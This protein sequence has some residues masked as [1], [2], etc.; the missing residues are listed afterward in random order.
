MK[1][2]EEDTARILA[3]ALHQLKNPIS[4]I[5]GSCEYLT[6]YSQENLEPEQREMVA[7]IETSAQTLLRLSGEL[8]RLFGLSGP[9]DDATI[10]AEETPAPSEGPPADA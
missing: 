2:H 8:S 7:A 1:K 10:A 3:A 6:E 9:K 4:S 5:I